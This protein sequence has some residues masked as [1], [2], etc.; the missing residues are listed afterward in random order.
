MTL[1]PQIRNTLQAALNEITN[2]KAQ[3]EALIV[4]ARGYD[5]ICTLIEASNRTDQGYGSDLRYAIHKLIAQDDA[6]REMAKAEPVSPV[7]Q[8]PANDNAALKV[9]SD[10]GYLSGGQRM[11]GMR[12]DA[13]LAAKVERWQQRVAKEATNDGGNYEDAVGLTAQEPIGYDDGNEGAG[14]PGEP[15]E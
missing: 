12:T 4:K 3:N 11:Q 6:E 2:L 14:H 1:H 9:A 13:E 8:E 5:A 7:A 15:T 10:N